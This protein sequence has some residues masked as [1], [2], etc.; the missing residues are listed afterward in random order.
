MIAIPQCAS[1]KHFD[2]QARGVRR[3]AAFPAGIPTPIL[4]GDADHTRSY[5]GDHGIRYERADEP[6]RAPGTFDPTEGF[7]F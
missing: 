5:Q 7:E 4:T 2:R 6:P 3:C 1:C